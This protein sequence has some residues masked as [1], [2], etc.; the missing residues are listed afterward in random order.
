MIDDVT[1]DIWSSEN[2]ASMENIRRKCNPMVDLSKFTSN[3][4]ILNEVV[5]L[6]Y[7]QVSSQILSILK[8][9][10]WK[11]YYEVLSLCKIIFWKRD[12]TWNS[13]NVARVDEAS[14]NLKIVFPNMILV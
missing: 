8:L 6:D 3:K 5:I 14:I 1:I 12:L 10:L 2:F 11:K 7:N 13:T 4:K 9:A